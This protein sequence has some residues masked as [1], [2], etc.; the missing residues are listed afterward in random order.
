MCEEL[1][2]SFDILREIFAYICHNVI[3]I[4][5]KIFVLIIWIS[6]ILSRHSTKV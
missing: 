5:G 3:L 1:C 6:T 4:I 2:L